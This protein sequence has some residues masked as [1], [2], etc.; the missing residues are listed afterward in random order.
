MARRSRNRRKRLATAGRDVS[1]PIQPS[2]RHRV[3]PPTSPVSGYSQH[4][5]PLLDTDR[6]RFDPTKSIAPL[7]ASKRSATRILS[8]TTRA[9]GKTLTIYRATQLALNNPI[10]YGRRKVGYSTVK[11]RLAFNVPRR[12][13]MC[14][15]RAV[16]ARVLHARRKTGKVGQR[17][18]RRNF[19]SA[20]SCR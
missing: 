7:G 19:W 5:V 9:I 15:R 4:S 11:E 6:R 18:P 2:P 8:K 12:I 14:I 20:I 3:P 17:R 16:R 1:T 10:K 13:E